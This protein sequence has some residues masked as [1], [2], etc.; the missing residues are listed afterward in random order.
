MLVLACNP[1]HLEQENS[2]VLKVSLG[3]PE[4]SY[5]K[6]KNKNGKTKIPKLK[7]KKKQVIQDYPDGKNNQQITEKPTLRILTFESLRQGVM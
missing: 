2:L 7:K 4:K 3:Y 6:N 5:I 1:T